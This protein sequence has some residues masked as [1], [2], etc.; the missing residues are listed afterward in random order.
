MSIKKSILDQRLEGLAINS[1]FSRSAIKWQ[2]KQLISINLYH[3]EQE[4]PEL[5][6]S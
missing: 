2:R 4:K 5:V 3:L 1:R 6:L